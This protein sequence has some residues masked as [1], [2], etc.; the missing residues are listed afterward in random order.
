[1]AGRIAA[2]LARPRNAAVTAAV[3]AASLVGAVAL[4][5]APAAVP[6]SSGLYACTVATDVFSCTAT[7][8]PFVTTT[9]T[10]TATVT[11]TV[12]TTATATVT[13][14]PSGNFSASPS[15]TPTLVVPSVVFGSSFGTNPAWTIANLAP[16]IVRTYNASQLALVPKGTRVIDSEK[17]NIAALSAGGSAAVQAMVARFSP[18]EDIPG[19]YVSIW[20]EGDKDGLVTADYQG[21]WQV[22]Q[23]KVLPALNAKRVN[24]IRS[25]AIV[26]GTALSRGNIKDYLVPEADAWGVDIYSPANI[27]PNAA[28]IKANGN[29]PWAVPEMGYVAGG[30]PTDGTDAQKLVR[31]KSDVAA[32]AA[33]P[34][35]PFAVLEFNNNGS[36]LGPS[37]LMAASVAW[38]RAVDLTGK[39]GP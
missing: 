22:F 1:M 21:A 37:P 29:K 33:Q 20:H 28:W 19:Q 32:Y 10:A 23:T 30:T 25:M 15:P 31:L 3:A 36:L 24:P 12:T 38:W 2:L 7:P 14:S 9:E 13:A 4:A 39:P 5:V 34:N 6:S 18:I 17:P 35:P 8:T 16:R 26:T 11:A 27:A